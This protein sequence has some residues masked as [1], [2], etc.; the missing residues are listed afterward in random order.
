MRLNVTFNETAA[1]FEKS[2][3][4]YLDSLTSVP[5]PLL[6][7]MKYSVQAGGKRLRPVLTF[8]GASV[9]DY[10]KEDITAIAIGIEL[11]HTY[12]LI[13]D[14]LPCMDN[15]TLRRGKP[16]SHIKFGEAF[17]LLAGDALLNQGFEVLSEIALKNKRYA[18]AV[19][20]I[21]KQ[22]G[23]IGM[24]AGQSMDISGTKNLL[25]MYRLKTSCLIKSALCGGAVA[26]GADKKTIKKLEQ[27]SDAV[28]IA[29]QIQDDILDVTGNEEI[30]GKN[31]GSDKNNGKKTLVSLLGI[32]Q[33]EKLR[34]SYVDKAVKAV[35]KLSVK[36]QLTDILN[37]LEK[38]SK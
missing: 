31:V 7:A 38:R 11:I 32:N 16:T 23:S 13:H 18:K 33:S 24:I 9:K 2:L 14:D 5:E 27:F 22:A 1:E 37:M 26:S 36:D 10:I 12:S 29:Y 35:S 8:I 21:S 25:E 17:A 4:Q 19:N 15:D 20:Y 30:L 34:K 28:G 3:N 6:S